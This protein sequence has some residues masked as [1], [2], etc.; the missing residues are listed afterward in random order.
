ML[1]GLMVVPL[2]ALSLL[3]AVRITGVLKVVVAVSGMAAGAPGGLMVTA[4]L[5]W[6]LGCPRL[7][8][9]VYGIVAVPTKPET[10]VKVTCPLGLPANVPCPE[11]V[12]LVWIP[13]V[14]GSRSRLLGLSVVPGALESLIIALTVTGLLNKP[15]PVSG[16]AV[17][18]L[19]GLM[20]TL[21]LALLLA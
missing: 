1:L 4:M 17:G 19:G 7:S 8:L 5:A 2:L 13:G 20:V 11:T 3:A 18:T 10:G 6:L 14:F 16:V 9:I 21:R 15:L 12:K